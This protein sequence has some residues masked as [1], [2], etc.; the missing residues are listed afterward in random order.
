MLKRNL[1]LANQKAEQGCLTNNWVKTNNHG[2]QICV[3][4]QQYQT[5][6]NCLKRKAALFMIDF[7]KAITKHLGVLL[8]K[9]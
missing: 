4:L 5:H 3:T 7:W 6:E 8:P 9:S 1:V 2:F